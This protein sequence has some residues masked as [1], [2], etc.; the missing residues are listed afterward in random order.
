[1]HPNESG[2]PPH[3]NQREFWLSHMVSVIIWAAG[4]CSSIG[5]V[6]VRVEGEEADGENTLKVAEC[7][8]E[9]LTIVPTDRSSR[10]CTPSARLIVVDW[11]CG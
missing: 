1:M 2:L 4:I 9:E 3:L 6:K 10:R 11:S 7:S 5:V 8:D